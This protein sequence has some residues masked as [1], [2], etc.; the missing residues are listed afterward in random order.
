MRCETVV[1]TTHL[2]YSTGIQSRTAITVSHAHP[3]RKGL[4]IPGHGGEAFPWVTCRSFVGQESGARLA[5]KK[6]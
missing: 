5:P 4:S 1:S 2:C 6:G 3:E